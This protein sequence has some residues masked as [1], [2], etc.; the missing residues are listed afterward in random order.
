MSSPCFVLLNHQYVQGFVM[1]CQILIN[2]LLILQVLF[3][4]CYLHVRVFC[5]RHPPP[6]HGSRRTVH[7]PTVGRTSFPHSW[8]THSTIQ[9]TE[10]YQSIPIV[11][12]HTQTNRKVKHICFHNTWK[13]IETNCMTLQGINVNTFE[14]QKMVMTVVNMLMMTTMMMMI[15]Y[16]WWWWLC[17]CCWWWW[18]WQQW[19]W[20]WWLWWR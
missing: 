13:T 2:C 20:W 12:N 5:S 16:W 10:I 18:L 8:T 17:C 6:H 19:W 7:S 11:V 14:S 9:G 4:E 1:S 3:W 15:C